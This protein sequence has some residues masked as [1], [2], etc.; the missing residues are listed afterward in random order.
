MT[1]REDNYVNSEA[2]VGVM[3]L[4]ARKCQELLA[5]TEARKRQ[6]SIL[7]ENPQKEHLQKRID[8]KQ[9]AYYYRK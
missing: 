4:Q 1:Q 9:L 6:G 2:E 5:T 3:L 8:P 7:P